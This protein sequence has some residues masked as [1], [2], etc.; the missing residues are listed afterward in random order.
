M[1]PKSARRRVGPVEGGRLKIRVH[2]APENGQ[3]NAAVVE[4]LAEI[5]QVPS[6]NITLL[7]G[8]TSRMKTIRI[9]GSQVDPSTFETGHVD[10][11]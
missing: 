5:F 7:Q 10:V 1:F 8:E 3:A 4:L 9:L 6:R 2:A 11:K